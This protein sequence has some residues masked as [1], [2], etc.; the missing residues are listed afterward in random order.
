MDDPSNYMDTKMLLKA[1]LKVSEEEK[2]ELDGEQTTLFR[3][4]VESLIFV[5]ENRMDIKYAVKQLA[6]KLSRPRACDLGGLKRLA[7][8][9]WHTWV[10]S[11]TVTE[12]N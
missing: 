3:R 7:R 2:M 8:Y 11:N 5:S 4:C 12:K 9:C 6:K 1:G 10:H